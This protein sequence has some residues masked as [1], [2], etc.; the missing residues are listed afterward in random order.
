MARMRGIVREWSRPLVAA[1]VTLCV[2]SPAWAKG[3]DVGRYGD[4][5]QAFTALGIFAGLLFILGRFAWKPIL[6][7]L[8]RREEEI[9]ERIRDSERREREAKE[10]DAEYRTQLDRAE[11]EAKQILAKSLDEAAKAREEMLVTAREEGNKA[12]EAAKGEIERFKQAA[13]EDLQQAMAG[14]AVDIASEII[15]EE[16]NAEKQHEL[17]DRSLQRIRDRAARDAG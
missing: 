4:L 15:R 8:K 14:L 2:A 11:A 16:F 17:I 1:A 12:I 7:Q 9:G 5:G 13:I 6:S 10:M 3:D